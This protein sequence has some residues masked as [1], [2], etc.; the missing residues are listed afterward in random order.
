MSNQKLHSSRSFGTL[1]FQPLTIPVID[2]GTTRVGLGHDDL[3][4]PSVPVVLQAQLDTPEAHIGNLVTLF[5]DGVEVQKFPLEQSHFD[6]N[7]ISFN[8]FPRDIKEPAGETYYTVYDP[9]GTGTGESPHRTVLVKMSIPGG[10][11]TD[12]STPYLNDRLGPPVVF[13]VLI[14]TPDT[15]VTVTVPA[16]QNMAV[17]DELVV[18]WNGIRLVQPPLTQSQV[19]NALIITV[20]RET[21]VAAGDGEALVINYEIRDLVNNYSLVSPPANA[22]VIIDPNAPPAPVALVKGQIVELIDLV[23]LGT[24]AVQVMIP[25]YSGIAVGDG[26]TLTWL[27]QTP[28]GQAVTVTLG[29][30]LVTSTFF[31]MQF[32]VPNAE[33]NAIAG[34]HAVLKYRVA[35][36]AGTAA[37]SSKSTTVSVNG[38]AM[39]LAAPG[40]D[41]VTGPLI[42]MAQLTGDPVVRVLPYVGKKLGDTLFLLW[43][44]LTQGG[45]SVVYTSDYTVSNGEEN[46]ATT[47]TV[48][49]SYLEPTV[50]GTLNLSYRMQ[51]VT[52]GLTR[53]SENRAYTVQGAVSEL[54]PAPTVAGVTQ[55]GELNPTLI[56][57]G[58]LVTI[59]YDSM[60]ATDAIRVAWFGAPPFIVQASG[61]ASKTVQVT[62]PNGAVAASLGQPVAMRYGVTHAGTNEE[63]ASEAITFRVGTLADAQLPTPVVPEAQNGVLDLNTFPGNASVTVAKWPL[64]AEGQKAW[65]ILSGPNGV[66]SVRLLDA[67]SITASEVTNGI[68]KGLPRP[69]L[70]LFADGDDITVLLKVTFDGRADELAAVE[71]PALPL[72]VVAGALPLS[73]DSSTMRLDG[74]FVAASLPQTGNVPP[75]CRAT[76]VATGGTPPYEYSCIPPVLA[77]VDSAGTVEKRNP[78]TGIIMVKD[79]DGQTA[80]YPLVTTKVSVVGIIYGSSWPYT[81]ALS[82][83]AQYNAQPFT[84]A[85]FENMKITYRQPFDWSSAF[86]GF[87]W[88][89]PAW[90]CTPQNC[91]PGNALGFNPLTNTFFCAGQND[92]RYITVFLV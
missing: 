20:P 51:S 71:F 62:I 79:A 40:I 81:T 68:A 27:G 38:T 11:D 63:L 29:P 73:I 74:F 45:V 82:H 24:D 44:G 39:P 42:D 10:L 60:V 89:Q 61:N 50:N 19:G 56:T 69:D 35:P 59:Q 46:I 83:M 70:D 21:L 32:Q 47:F 64:I 13:P 14:T 78:G 53:P 8:V 26:I 16:W 57:D 1:A 91:T 48:P 80:S 33:V 28:E 25:V 90:A 34:G 6:S 55:G 17:G 5:W 37:R 4:D 22:E 49:R 23:A 84:P 41:G 67:Y 92:G 12:T 87:N 85:A 88:Q 2:F 18:M 7:F 31:P 15:A 65:L 43:E 75:G 58:V 86:P 36:V 30:L 52:T 9:L 77:V 72:K 3:N 54:L 66:P 76:R